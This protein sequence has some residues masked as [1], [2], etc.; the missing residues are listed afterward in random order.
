M[1][2]EI[3]KVNERIS[4]VL[5]TLRSQIFFIFVKKVE[6]GYSRIGYKW[7]ILIDS[8]DRGVWQFLFYI[9]SRKILVLSVSILTS[10]V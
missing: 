10:L 2:C 1:S 9:I 5:G 6:V 8:Y 4:P 3:V 7:I